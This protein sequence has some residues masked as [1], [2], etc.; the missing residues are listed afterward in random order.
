MTRKMP[1]SHASGNLRRFHGVSLLHSMKTGSSHRIPQRLPQG[2]KLGDELLTQGLIVLGADGIPHICSLKLLCGLDDCK[3]VCSS[4]TRHHMHIRA[5]QVAECLYVPD[6]E[7]ITE[8]KGRKV[9][10]M[11]CKNISC[12]DILAAASGQRHASYGR[13]ASR[14]TLACKVFVRFLFFLAG[15]QLY[16]RRILAKHGLRRY[17]KCPAWLVRFRETDR[18]SAS[19]Q[20]MVYAA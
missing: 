12:S 19:T 2:A 8:V 1:D 9:M 6:T 20:P 16:G 5:G 3:Q 14:A 15:A 17:T 4:K 7:S 18:Q 11:Q 10:S 13:L